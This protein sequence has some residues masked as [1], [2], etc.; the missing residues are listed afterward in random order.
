MLEAAE[1]WAATVQPPSA[2]EQEARPEIDAA[3]VGVA[4]ADAE[5][6]P[7]LDEFEDARGAR[8][9]EVVIYEADDGRLPVEQVVAGVAECV[10]MQALQVRPTT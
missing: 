2:E 1:V 6:A 3:R 7:R 5:E 10:F 8:G 4:L 9:E